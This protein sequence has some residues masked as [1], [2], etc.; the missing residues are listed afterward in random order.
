M[1]PVII[2]PD[3]TPTH[4]LIGLVLTHT[5][6]HPT[7]RRAFPKG[8]SLTESD[9]PTLTTILHTTH[10]PIHAVRLDPDD[11]LED[12]AAQR[13]ATALLG[14]STGTGVAQRPPIQSRVN[15]EATHKGLL[16][17]DPNAIFTINRHPGIGVFTAIDRLPVLPGTI[18]AGAKIAPVAIP[19]HT[20]VTIEHTL[21]SLPTPAIHVKPFL[22]HHVGIIVTEG[23][24]ER[25]RTRFEL[26]VRRKLAWYGSD[27]LR[28]AH[29][30]NDPTTIAN[31]AT[32]LLHHGATLLLSAGGTM[33]DPLDPTL[34]AL[35]ALD[36][37]LV[38]LGAPAHP[39]SMFW[40]GYTT[41]G[42]PVVNLA[43]CSMYSR[44]TVADL[45]LP[46]IIAGEHVTSDD[47]AALGYGGLLDRTTSW[48]FPPY[49][50]D[51][52]HEPDDEE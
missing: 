46:W 9:I 23:L 39:G 35:P 40:L 12:P 11:I 2:R 3:T 47:L 51:Q 19:N 24:D 10:T 48:R 6:L 41:T 4:T 20:L 26:A 13:L 28:F 7:G 21:A 38:R 5:I 1:H 43:S 29:V 14:S 49:D 17:V 44:S 8:H 52:A 34:Q 18:V 36:A 33:M 37:H 22:P 15:L 45:V 30:P 50:A 16:R 42:I 25:I 31:A 27:I 32:S